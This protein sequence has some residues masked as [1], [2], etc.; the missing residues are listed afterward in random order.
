MPRSMLLTSFTCWF[1]WS[2][3]KSTLDEFEYPTQNKLPPSSP[4]EETSV[5]GALSCFEEKSSRQLLEEDLN[6]DLDKFNEKKEKILN[7]TSGRGHGSVLD[8]NSFLF[9]IEDLPRLATLQLCLPQYLS[10]LQQSL[11]RVSAERGFY[12]PKQVENMDGVVDLLNSSFEFYEEMKNKG[13]PPEDARYILPL[14]TRTNIQTLGDARELMHLHEMSNREGVPEVIRYVVN[15]M[16]E[17]AKEVAPLLMKKRETNYEV[18][19]WY[20]SSQLFAK[21]NKLLEELIEENEWDRTVMIDYSDFKIKSDSVTRAVKQRDEAELA[22]VK[23][24]QDA[25]RAAAKPIMDILYKSVRAGDES[26]T[27]EATCCPNFR[28]RLN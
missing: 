4:I 12:L 27:A 17:K 3:N 21:R 5:Y 28:Q 26:Q 15:E 6:T 22:T 11:R 20:P 8:Q 9:V 16:I 25:T 23:I 18:L 7:E 10:H 1:G 24:Y 14:S 13:I 2:S 19:A